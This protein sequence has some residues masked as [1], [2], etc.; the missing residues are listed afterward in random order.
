MSSPP[1]PRNCR[2]RVGLGQP[3][4]DPRAA[5]AQASE[6]EIQRLALQ[7]I[8]RQGSMGLDIPSDDENDDDEFNL[9]TSDSED[10]PRARAREPPSPPPQPAQVPADAQPVAS[11]SAR[12]RQLWQGNHPKL[13]IVARLFLL[14][15]QR[16]E[17]LAMASNEP[18]LIRQ[19]KRDQTKDFGHDNF[20]HA[21]FSFIVQKTCEEL[22]SNQAF[23]QGYLP[24]N[25]ILSAELL[26]QKIKEFQ[27][28]AVNT[29]IQDIDSRNYTIYYVHNSNVC[30]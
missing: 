27:L 13:N 22:N 7:Q 14:Q 19:L 25:S 17:M 29:N 15:P 23:V 2:R 6:A 8:V 24:Q 1:P 10:Y 18:E 9:D 11:L 26:R 16:Q 28:I 21:G 12:S 30:S 20:K 3:V 4:G 5:R